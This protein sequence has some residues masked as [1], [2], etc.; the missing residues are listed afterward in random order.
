VAASLTNTE[1]C[2]AGIAA[3]YATILSYRT[4]RLRDSFTKTL[5]SEAQIAPRIVCIQNFQDEAYDQRMEGI[6]RAPSLVASTSDTYCCSIA[7]SKVRE[8]RLKDVQ[9]SEQDGIAPGSSKE[10]G[11]KVNYFKSTQWYDTISSTIFLSNQL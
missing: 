4:E 5:N 6:S 10:E 3:D 8:D 11:L 7:E 9:S 2:C 1:A